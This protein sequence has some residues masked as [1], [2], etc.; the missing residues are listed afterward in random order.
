MISSAKE[1]RRKKD[2]DETN[3]RNNP[4]LRATLVVCPPLHA[5]SIRPSPAAA[6]RRYRVVR[7]TAGPPA[8]ATRWSAAPRVELAGADCQLPVSRSTAEQTTE[9]RTDAPRACRCG[10]CH[11]RGRAIAAQRRA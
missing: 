11:Y 10:A 6:Q 7:F 9:G 2:T 3:N 5:A 8:P 1:T 4:V